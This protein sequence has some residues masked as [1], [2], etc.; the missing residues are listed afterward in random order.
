MTATTLKQYPPMWDDGTY[1][2]WE[3]S[4][5]HPYV[6]R[7]RTRKYM[8]DAVQ[9]DPTE[10]TLRPPVGPGSIKGLIK[11]RLVDFIPRGETAAPAKTFQE[12]IEVR[13]PHRCTVC[14][15]RTLELF[16]SVDHADEQ[17]NGGAKCPGPK[18]MK[19]KW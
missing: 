2:V 8:K 16:S 17:G 1:G 19:G 5:V 18:K 4:I 13:F 15:G 7:S 14:G 10:I 3:A 9:I 12:P 6:P 11:V